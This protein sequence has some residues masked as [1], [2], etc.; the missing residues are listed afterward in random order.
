MKE[1]KNMSKN[2]TR[3]SKRDVKK[4][5]YAIIGLVLVAAMLITT[6]VSAFFVY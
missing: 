1:V 5:I 4:Q 6:F 2:N 3:K